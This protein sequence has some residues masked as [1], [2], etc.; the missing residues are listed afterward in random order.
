ML[1]DGIDVVTSDGAAGL[2]WGHDHR[3]A[4]GDEV[5]AVITVAVRLP[6]R[7]LT[8]GRRLFLFGSA[9]KSSQTYSLLYS[10]DQG[11]SFRGL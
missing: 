10:D 8:V 7:L 3:W 9:S 6:T 2:K 11:A 1:G 4:P 5:A